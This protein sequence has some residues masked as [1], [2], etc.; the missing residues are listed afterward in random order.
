MR[1]DGRDKYYKLYRPK[2][3][4]RH[5]LDIR[6]YNRKYGFLIK[7]R[8][9]EKLGGKCAK[10]RTTDIRLLQVNHKN[11]NGTRELRRLGSH[12]FY[13]L[14]LSGKRATNDL[15]LR[16][17]NCNLLY[18]YETGRRWCPVEERGCLAQP[19]TLHESG[20]PA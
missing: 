20:G 5:R 2:Y 1:K 12:D 10:C 13:R 9:V 6:T 16:C 17:A 4:R 14:I 3:R 11:G 18:E 19:I 15:E 7:K 8:I